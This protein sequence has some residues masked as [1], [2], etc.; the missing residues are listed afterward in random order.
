MPL[1]VATQHA[2][3]LFQG[4]PMW[5]KKEHSLEL[6][7]P[8]ADEKANGE[9]ASGN[10]AARMGLPPPNALPSWRPGPDQSRSG[11]AA[12][13]KPAAATRENGFSA[14]ATAAKLSA[15]LPLRRNEFGSIARPLAQCPAAKNAVPGSSSGLESSIYA[16]A[17][18]NPIAGPYAPGSQSQPQPQPPNPFAKQHSWVVGPSVRSQTAAT[19][20]T[21]PSAD[22]VDMANGSGDE[23]GEA[24]AERSEQD[25]NPYELLSTFEERE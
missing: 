17:A 23:S 25:A 12:H 16:P 8:R 10:G 6:R 15:P 13:Q 4:L 3:G 19:P 1:D 24:E 14:A 7:T 5:Y 9:A 11:G 18:L 21:M 22:R 2:L 20:A